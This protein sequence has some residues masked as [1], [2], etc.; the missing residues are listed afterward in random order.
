[1]SRILDERDKKNI[2]SNMSIISQDIAALNDDMEENDTFIT[3]NLNEH[4]N[5]T[6]NPHKVTYLQVGA[7][8]TG[9]ASKALNDAKTYT[10]TKMAAL[11]D[12]A[13][14]ALDTLN[15]LSAALNDDG[16]FATT[17][18]T[19]LGKKTNNTD[20]T[21]HTINVSNPHEVTKA[22]VGLGNV[23]NVATND[24]VPTYTEASTLSTLA[25]GEKL[26]VSLGKIMKAITD[27]INHIANKS[28]PHSVTK[29]QVGLGN[30][31]NTSDVNKPV[32]TAQATAIA[33]AKKSGTDAQGTIDSHINNTNNPHE[34]TIAQIGAD[35]AGSATQALTDAKK[36]TDS[37]ISTIESNV[38]F[39]LETNRTLFD[40]RI[41]MLE[42]RV[43]LPTISAENEGK[44]LCVVNGAYTLVSLTD[45]IEPVS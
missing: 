26:S 43:T 13:P 23:P 33:D 19:E 37:K 2:E 6:S 40:N 41:S 36:Y 45:L 18:T 20:F 17:M 24:Q 32:S 9:A 10:D 5:N 34:V 35:A 8:P 30:A 12:S 31:D 22:Q 29:T 21:A 1:M 44:V 27:L 4:K 39:E 15:E 28:N 42:N 25:S 14:A 16:N 38:E 7:D 11:V 3:N